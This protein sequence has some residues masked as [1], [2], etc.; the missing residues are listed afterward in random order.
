MGMLREHPLSPWLGA[1]GLHALL[2]L[3]LQA[4]AGAPVTP[5][6]PLITEVVALAPE[7]APT[8][9]APEP[10]PKPTQPQAKPE[11]VKRQA[12]APT[13][14]PV[15][16]PLT[17]SASPLAQGPSASKDAD[18]T[19]PAPAAKPT[20]ATGEPGPAKETPPSFSAAYLS[21]PEP[22]YPAASLELGE[23][24]NVLLR[25]AVSAEG[26]PTSVEISRSSGYGRLDRAALSAVK[27]WRF[28]PARRGSEAV[29]G[30]VLV[31]INF[32]IKQ[33]Q[34]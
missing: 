15:S 21:N 20:A 30:V 22:A 24:G 7:A 14:R 32:Q 13:P 12:A 19:P 18:P 17:P 27:R 28:T 25:V 4:S 11:P 5:P 26:Q 33:Q 23:S 9:P 6:T 2:L 29:A 16:A 8:P 31:P 34:G 3:A 10:K 1:L